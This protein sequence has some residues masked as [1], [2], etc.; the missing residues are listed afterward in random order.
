[1][2]KYIF[3]VVFA[4]FSGIQ[5]S[6]EIIYELYD[7]AGNAVTCP[8]INE[9]NMSTEEL[10]YKGDDTG[11]APWQAVMYAEDPGGP[12]VG[13]SVTLESTQITDGQV[14]LKLDTAG[15]DP[16]SI[17]RIPLKFEY[18]PCYAV[19]AGQPV[20]SFLDLEPNQPV[21]ISLF[22]A[23][24]LACTPPWRTDVG[25]LKVTR[26]ALTQIPEDGTYTGD[27]TLTLGPEGG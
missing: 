10:C 14:Y 6:A 26:L 8:P 16:T 17:Q 22:Y 19:D 25:E 11:N 1:M 3:A 18:K 7:N 20:P 23:S 27:F 5:A 13:L 2:K 12:L 4:L 15:A 9:V 21:S 24:K